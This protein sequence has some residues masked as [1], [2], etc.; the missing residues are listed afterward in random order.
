MSKEFKTPC[1]L[2]FY[3]SNI[4]RMKPAG[5]DSSP[6]IIV[7]DILS[8]RKLTTDKYVLQVRQFLHS[9]YSSASDTSVAALAPSP[10]AHTN[11]KS[12]KNTFAINIKNRKSKECADTQVLSSER[13]NGKS[14][15]SPGK[16]SFSC[17]LKQTLCN[18]FRFR[19]PEPPPDTVIVLGVPHPPPFSKRALPPLPISNQSTP[20]KHS[21][22][23]I[24]DS[25]ENNMDFASSIEKVK[26]VSYFID[27][28]TPYFSKD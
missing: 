3:W 2:V 5:I 13:I 1:I 26:D 18:L 7:Y 8:N 23:L 21:L 11:R 12:N 10:P 15:K 28:K 4:C 20:G 14:K 19:R 22:Q 27:L 16:T 17:T 9:L 24:E 25:E 6:L